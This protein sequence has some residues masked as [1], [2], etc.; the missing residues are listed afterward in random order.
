[1]QEK[2]ETITINNVEYVRK[3]QQHKMAVNTEGLPFVI[4]RS[5]RAGVFAGY[6]KSHQGQEVELLN[7]IRLWKWSGAS[8][9]QVS[10]EG[11]P[12][13]ANCKFGMT[14]PIKKIMTVIEITPCT[15]KA[16][17]A[18]ESVKQWKI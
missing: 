11:T 10:Q 14:E 17:V 7:S 9:S 12:N 1:M 2:I 18:I 13:P 15:E 6:L 5:D 8:L 3:D 4:I 16:R